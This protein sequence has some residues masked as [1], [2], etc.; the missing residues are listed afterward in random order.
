MIFSDAVLHEKNWIWDR[1]ILAG[2]VKCLEVT[3]KEGTLE[4]SRLAVW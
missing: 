2:A 1:K 3:S 4:P